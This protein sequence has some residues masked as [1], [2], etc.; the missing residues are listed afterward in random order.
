MSQ[1]GCEVSAQG[2]SSFFDDARTFC[3]TRVSHVRRPRLSRLFCRLGGVSLVFRANQGFGTYTSD[4]VLVLDVRKMRACITGAAVRR[5]FIRR[6]IVDTTKVSIASRGSLSILVLSSSLDAAS[7]RTS[8]L[9]TIRLP[10]LVRNEAKR[11]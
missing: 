5:I 11:A 3:D 8:C 10:L 2:L 4:K 6:I 9:T 1:S 7:E